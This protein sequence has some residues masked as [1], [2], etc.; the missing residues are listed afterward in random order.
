MPILKR[1]KIVNWKL[2]VAKNQGSVLKPRVT[3]DMLFDKY[4]KQKA[5]MSD[6]PIKKDEVTHT[7]REAIIASQSSCQVQ[8]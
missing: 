8:G 7:S 4:S 3:F 6:R 5:V 1:L 2:N